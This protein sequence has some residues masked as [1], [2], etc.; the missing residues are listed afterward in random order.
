MRPLTDNCPKPLILVC[1]KPILQH[2]VEALPEEIDE[3]IIVVSYLEEQIRAYCG[4]DFCGRKVMYVHQNNPAGGTG[5]ALLCARELLTDKFMVLNG[6]DIHGAKALRAAV[7][8]EHAILAVYSKTPELFGV[9]EK[10]EDGT[11]KAI[12][13]KPRHPTSNLVNTGGFVTDVS[14]F[15]HNVAVSVSGEVYVTVML[16]RSAGLYSIKIIEQDFWLPIGY[17]EDIAIAEAV[18]CPKEN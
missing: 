14:L 12:I 7:E 18:L 6:D 4:E 8:E 3:I 10:N 13:E 5:S 17:P 1:D 2:I 15:E 16:T 11:L 9:L